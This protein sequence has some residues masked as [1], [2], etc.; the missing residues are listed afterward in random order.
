MS[1]VERL[2]ARA[3][4]WIMRRP[5]RAWWVTL[6]GLFV[7]TA[8]VPAGVI[9]QAAARG[10]WAPVIAVTWMV[11]LAVLPLVF[12]HFARRRFD[13][14]VALLCLM[15]LPPTMLALWAAYRGGGRWLPITG[16]VLST[17]ALEL[18][19]R[20]AVRDAGRRPT[21]DS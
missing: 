8:A 3:S 18:V 21:A 17:L 9:E 15:C 6:L 16:W 12:P 7:I 2:Q 20:R 1:R 4:A 19:L 10:D 13:E 14:V 5:G 11:V